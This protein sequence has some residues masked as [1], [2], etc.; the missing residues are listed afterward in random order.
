MVQYEAMYGCHTCSLFVYVTA[1]GIRYVSFNAESPA[2]S[3]V[4][5]A[6]DYDMR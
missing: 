4:V 3:G 1:D 5:F 2:I 6:Y